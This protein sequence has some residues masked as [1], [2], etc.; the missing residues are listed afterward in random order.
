M[1]DKIQ[2]FFKTLWR[3]DNFLKCILVSIF[4]YFPWVFFVKTHIAFPE[5]V[6]ESVI[7]K[8][9]LTHATA[10]IFAAL[11]LFFLIMLIA[12]IE[13]IVRGYEKEYDDVKALHYDK[14]AKKQDKL[15]AEIERL[16]KEIERLK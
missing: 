1:N 12:L 7:E 6:E 14:K 4:S 13:E 3:L 16:K 8:F 15:E 11:T 9:L 5:S 2:I 10:L